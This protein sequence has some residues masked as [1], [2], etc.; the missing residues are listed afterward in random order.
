MKISRKSIVTLITVS[1]Y[2][3]AFGILA[4]LMFEDIKCFQRGS[5]CFR[6]CSDN[7]DDY[8][9]EF[10]LTEFNQSK[11]ASSIKLSNVIVYRGYPLCGKMEFSQPNTNI[12]S[13][14]RPYS[15]NHHASI[16][17]NGKHY[18]YRRYCLEKS[19]NALDGWKLMICTQ[20]EQ[21]HKIFHFLTISISV[22][23]NAM[24]LLVY[25]Y[26]KKLRDFHGKCAIALVIN[27]M[28][29][30][31]LSTCVDLY[32]FYYEDDQ[33]EILFS[34][35]K[36]FVI[37][38]L[39]WITVM[40]LHSMFTFI[41]YTNETEIPFDF[42]TY[43]VYVISATIIS[44]IVL[45]PPYFHYQYRTVYTACFIISV[46]DGI[47]V[48]FTAIKIFIILRNPDYSSNAKFHYERKWFRICVELATIFLLIWIVKYIFQHVQNNFLSFNMIDL[49]M[50]LIAIRTTVIFLGDK[51]VRI[52]IFEKFHGNKIE[53]KD[54]I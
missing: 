49:L 31:I 40:I 22:V 14:S 10:L 23:L 33:E 42:S 30:Y 11:S 2:V 51:N 47:F 53:N 41:N 1:S 38:T 27:Q 21:I 37:N 5:S 24:T 29:I 39:L 36:L 16:Y 19:A 44:A 17:I 4:K 54:A 26:F 48:I 3:I 25:I 18:D 7:S 8:S 13:D 46:L 32:D 50:L 12:T 6:F 15:F 9:D 43:A 52:L 45:L 35:L 28:F 34:I 20:D